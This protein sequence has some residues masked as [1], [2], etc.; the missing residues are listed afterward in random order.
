MRIDR[1]TN[2]VAE[3]KFRYGRIYTHLYRFPR[4]PFLFL[5]Q[6]YGII[7]V[8]AKAYALSYRSW[9]KR[10]SRISSFFMSQVIMPI[11]CIRFTL[12]Q[13]DFSS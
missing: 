2:V 11:K 5:I 3:K 13:H 6:H 7:S 1:M 10:E 4:V 9:G 8:R 12:W